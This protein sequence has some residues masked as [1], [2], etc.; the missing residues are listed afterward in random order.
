LIIPWRVDV[1]QDRWPFMNWLIIAGIFAVFSLQFTGVVEIIPKQESN[2]QNGQQGEE[3]PQISPYVLNGW[4]IKGLFGHMWLHGGIIHLLGNLLF[5]W[6]FGNAVCAK[7]GNLKYLPIY[8]VLGLLAAISHLLFSGGLA[9][10][11]S[12]AINGIVGMYL[13]FFPE[14]DITCYFVF[15][16]FYYPIIRE[17][18]IS[19]YAMILFWFT[20]DL[21]G[22]LASSPGVG[23]VAYFAHIGGFLAGVAAAIILLKTR[24]V[25]MEERY[26]KSLLKIIEERFKPAEPE[27]DPRFRDFQREMGLVQQTAETKDATTQPTTIPLPAKP[28]EQRKP[29]EIKPIHLDDLMKEDMIRFTC[30]C[31]KRFKVPAKYAGKTGRCPKCKRRLRIPSAQ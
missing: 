31:G 21:L 30:P 26:E 22:A 24:L 12:G 3:E 10:G 23:G 20:F 4:E 7:I 5:L 14:N 18:T 2:V 28:V 11:A 8:I 27:S 25:V 1:P 13:I 29:K 9:I 15:I 17:F 6:I 19:S 16:L